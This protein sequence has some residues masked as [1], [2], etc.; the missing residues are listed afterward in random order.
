MALD[1]FWSSEWW[2]EPE[3]YNWG[4]GNEWAT[5]NVDGFFWV[6]QNVKETVSLLICLRITL[7]DIPDGKSIDIVLNPLV[8]TDTI[9]GKFKF[10]TNHFLQEK[11][12]LIARIPL[13]EFE[14]FFCETMIYFSP[15]PN[16]DETKQVYFTVKKA[17]ELVEV[18]GSEEELS[19]LLQ[20]SY[21]ANVVIH[22]LRD[23][24][25]ELFR[26]TKKK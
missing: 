18:Y 13:Q 24:V 1:E 14:T 5:F 3:D 25:I 23:A 7:W 22:W 19:I 10:S 15:Y 16:F 9:E 26:K 2:G 11:S 4:S 8:E 17:W 12:R 20:T 6:P 21:K